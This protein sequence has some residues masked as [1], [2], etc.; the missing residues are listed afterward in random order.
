MDD[1]PRP[2][3][4]IYYKT[5]AVKLTIRRGYVPHLFCI[6][7]QPLTFNIKL[8][9]NRHIETIA[10]KSAESVMYAL[11]N[12]TPKTGWIGHLITDIRG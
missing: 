11:E 5:K 9:F 7:G 2:T 6:K 10:C 3:K 12:D 8:Y 1:Q 4:V